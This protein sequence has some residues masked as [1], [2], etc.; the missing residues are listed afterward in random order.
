MEDKITSS[1]R[2]IKDPLVGTVVDGLYKIL[3]S[4]GQGATSSV[5]KAAQVLTGQIV[6]IKI[7][8]PHLVSDAN[9]VARFEREAQAAAILSHPNIVAVHKYAISDNGTP[10]L[11]MDFVDGISLAELLAKDRW[12]EQS[13]AIPIFTQICAALAEAHQKGIVHRDI[14]P[15]N[16]MLTERPD[17]SYFVKVLDFGCAKMAPML[18]DTV[19]KLTQTGEMLGSLLYMSPEQCLDEEVD[20]RSD[21]YSLGCMLYET[22][23]GKAPLAARTA[24]ETMNKQLSAM[25]DTLQHAR[26]DLAFCDT[27]QKIIFKAMA[28]SPA[29]RYQNITDLMDDLLTLPSQGAQRPS[30]RLFAGAERPNYDIATLKTES[31]RS[32]ENKKTVADKTIDT[33]DTQSLGRG[34]S[35]AFSL[36]ELCLMLL[37]TPI[38]CIT[39]CANLGM[40][41]GIIISFF[42]VV[43]V[44]MLVVIRLMESANLANLQDLKGR[45][46]AAYVNG[47]E[48]PSSDESLLPLASTPFQKTETFIYKAV[49]EKDGTFSLEIGQLNAPRKR[50]VIRPL[51]GYSF[52]WQTFCDGVP[53]ANRPTEF[54]MP[55]AVFNNEKDASSYLIVQKHLARV[56]N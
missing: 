26:P 1:V 2:V 21:C 53:G 23:T 35:R 25:P 39:C 29:N 9:L 28:K 43:G 10:Y 11:V 54:P 32:E 18:G 50:L 8:H 7:L 52:F 47:N 46:G 31:W 55:A 41:S 17:S 15:G 37:V 19:L 42:L 36:F 20:G 30:M 45:L 4:I 5:Y 12:L 56:K 33:T 3:A 49:R 14:K 51:D 6:A 44:G 34:Q 22:L 16:I 24:F 38:A 13:T 48:R 40:V 27:V